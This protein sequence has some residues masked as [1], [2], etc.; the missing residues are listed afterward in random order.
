MRNGDRSEEEWR[1]DIW[2]FYVFYFFLQSLVIRAYIPYE[3]GTPAFRMMCNAMAPS[4]TCFEK[5]FLH[6]L[7]GIMR[8]CGNKVPV[9]E[10][11]YYP[12]YKNGHSD[13]QNLDLYLEDFLISC[14]GRLPADVS[15]CWSIELKDIVSEC[16]RY[17]YYGNAGVTV[18]FWSNYLYSDAIHRL[19][20]N[21]HETEGR[22]QLIYESSKKIFEGAFLLPEIETD[23]GAYL[24]LIVPLL[25]KDSHYGIMALRL[26]DYLNPLALYYIVELY[27][28]IRQ[29]EGSGG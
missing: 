12:V 22:L 29:I 11:I 10:I 28:E 20:K 1:Y 4:V 6:L 2:K 14:M 17:G 13:F 18:L 9:H 8:G 15:L 16:A 24:G 23:S 5:D 25:Q 26:N 21:D 19:N 3:G 27:Y 7:C